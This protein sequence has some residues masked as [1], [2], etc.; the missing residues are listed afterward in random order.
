MELVATHLDIISCG[1]SIK[2]DVRSCFLLILIQALNEIVPLGTSWDDSM[3]T[4]VTNCFL[5]GLFWYKSN[6]GSCRNELRKLKKG[7]MEIEIISRS[8]HGL[9]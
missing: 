9:I 7:S 2:T 1:D 3:K 5:H 4:E 8:L 6:G